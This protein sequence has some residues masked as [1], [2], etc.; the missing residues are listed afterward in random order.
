[1][2]TLQRM[3]AA[4]PGRRQFLAAG[5]GAGL[6]ASGAGLPRQAAAAAVIGDW[7]AF[8]R[9]FLDADGRVRDTGNGGISHSEGQGAGLLFA[10][11]FDDRPSFERILA[12]TRAVLR[13]PDDQLLAWAYRPGAPIP[14]PDLNNASDGDLLVAWALAEAAE[15]WGRPDYRALAAEMA[16]DLLRRVVLQQGDQTLLLPGAEGFLKPDHVV[17]NPSYYITPAFRVLARLQ[18]SPQWRALEEDGLALVDQ[19]RFGRW[20]L[21]ADWVALSRGAARPAPAQGWPARFSYDAIRVPLNLAW[22]GHAQA[23]ALRAAVDFWQ[24]PAHAAPPAWVDLRSNAVAPYPAD[25]GQRAILQLAA[26]TLAGRGRPE[27]LP[28]VAEAAAY[29]PA[30][31]TLQ[32]RIAWAERGLTEGACGSGAL[33]VTQPPAPGAE[34]APGRWLRSIW[35]AALRIGG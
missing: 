35:P 26:A 17:V 32:A 1:M 11:R 13:R 18:P 6:G 20:R 10:V 15:R 9:R 29:Y 34:A 5:L 31:L 16:R 27:A 14:V 21:P 3:A 8:R 12:W 23:A 24:D 33:L 22:G 19:A 30:V 28:G 25:T 4:R 7:L 2:P